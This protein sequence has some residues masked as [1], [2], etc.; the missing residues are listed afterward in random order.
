LQCGIAFNATWRKE[1]QS[2]CSIGGS[3]SVV[4]AFQYHIKRKKNM[5][6]ACDIGDVA[7]VVVTPHIQQHWEPC[8]LQIAIVSV[9]D[10]VQKNQ[11]AASVGSVSMVMAF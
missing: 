6:S 8:T 9:V 1:K 11:P 10:F 4:M 5:Q 3:V 2:T 7:A